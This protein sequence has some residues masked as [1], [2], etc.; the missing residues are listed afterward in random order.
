MW[1]LIGPFSHLKTWL[2]LPGFNV[3]QAEDNI[4]SKGIHK[5][6]YEPAPYEPAPIPSINLPQILSQYH[7]ILDQ[8]EVLKII[9]SSDVQCFRGT[10]HLVK[11]MKNSPEEWN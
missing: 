8:N 4:D 3:T 5:A 11:H 9:S 7:L 10:R 6:S 1:L 2:F